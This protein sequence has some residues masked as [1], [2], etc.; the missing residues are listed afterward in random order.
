[1][2]R[3]NSNTAS[4]ARSSPAP[5]AEPGTLVR[6]KAAAAAIGIDEEELKKRAAA[7]GVKVHTVVRSG[8]AQA[9]FDLDDVWRLRVETAP[10]ETAS[11]ESHPSGLEVSRLA[12]R[13]EREAEEHRSL[14]AEALERT[15]WLEDA[16]RAGEQA[17]RAEKSRQALI[18]SQLSESVRSLSE[19]QRALTELRNAQAKR[20]RE[21]NAS[22]DE[23]RKT[24]AVSAQALEAQTRETKSAQAACAQA[25][26]QVQSA[27]KAQAALKLE[28]ETA[29]QD[30]ERISKELTEVKALRVRLVEHEAAIVKLNATVAREQAETKS[31]RELAKTRETE[32]ARSAKE[33]ERLAP[34]E[35]QLAVAGAG[36]QPVGRRV[37]S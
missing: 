31:A 2:A 7:A 16:L 3:Q 36:D 25:E 6:L 35:K 18:E 34:F 26:G 5:T 14:H 17:V 28:L 21:L 1:M 12:A 9:A 29:R 24:A 33:C 37:A 15:R 23:E 13:L 22:L 27:Q 4:A 20:E 11:L 32:A 30:N 19:A 10:Q 8:E